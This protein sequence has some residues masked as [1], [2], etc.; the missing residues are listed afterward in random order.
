[1]KETRTSRTAPRLGF[2]FDCLF[3]CLFLSVPCSMRD[4]T[5]PT[6]DR[7]SGPCSGSAA[8]QPLDRQG[9]PNSKVF[10]SEH[11]EWSCHQLEKR[12]N[13]GKV[14]GRLGILGVE[15]EQEFS[16]GHVE[17]ETSDIQRET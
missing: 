17:F 9:S 4:L 15:G 5:S 13:W 6:R 10:L 1:M 16:L 14:A 3:V 12:L 7:T 11:L 8:S 2:L